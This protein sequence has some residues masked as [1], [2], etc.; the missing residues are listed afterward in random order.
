MKKSSEPDLIKAKMKNHCFFNL[1]RSKLF[2]CNLIYKVLLCVEKY[3][4]DFD[5]DILDFIILI[6]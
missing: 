4:L 6:E 3:Y 2:Y 5:T 1:F